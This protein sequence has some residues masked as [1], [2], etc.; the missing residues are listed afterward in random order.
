VPGTSERVETTDVAAWLEAYG[1]AWES[2]ETSAF[3][4]LFS[5]DVTYHWT[6][7]DA[8]QEGR[9]QLAEAFE[10]AIARQKNIAFGSTVLAIDGRRALAHWRCSFERSESERRVQLDG[11]FLIEF[12]DERK[13]TLF[14]EWWHSDE[15][16]SG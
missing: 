7:F 1:T 14:R 12:G 5:P 16:A 15:P 3:V 10:S 4:R 2:K 13:C 11:I 6:P 9:E 8:P